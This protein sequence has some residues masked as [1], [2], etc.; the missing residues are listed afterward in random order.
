MENSSGAILQLNKAACDLIGY[1]YN[2]MIGMHLEDITHAENLTGSF[3][4]Q[5][6]I[7]SGESDN[8][9]MALR[10]QHK[11][12]HY[13]PVEVTNVLIRNDEGEPYLS[14]LELK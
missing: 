5:K 4:N 2:E 9:T 14:I 13:V 7:L 3:E 11:Q 6:K 1:A 8:Y 10:Y 12:G